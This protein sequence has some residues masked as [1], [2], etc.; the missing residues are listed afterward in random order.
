MTKRRGLLVSGGTLAAYLLAS[1]AAWVGGPTRDTVLG[2]ATLT[3]SGAQLAPGA[4]ALGLVVAAGLVVLA[5]G[6]RRIRYAAA[7]LISAAA[8]GVAILGIRPLVD[9]A[10]ALGRLAADQA[11]RA[12]SVLAV[13][14][15]VLPLGWV[16]AALGLGLAVS[17]A[18][19]GWSARQ[20]R[21]LSSRFD[22][23]GDAS[24][25]AAAG[26]DDYGSAP[27][28]AGR[29]DWDALSEGHDPTVVDTPGQDRSAT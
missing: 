25:A 28:G 22:R 21:G 5:T 24:A 16:A 8:L 13:D 23:Q 12:G 2:S 10:T 17:C 11:G 20:W 29:S 14:A 19:T 4:T 15:G 26:A 1:T 9:P 7:A 27:A 18:W 3:A 6:G